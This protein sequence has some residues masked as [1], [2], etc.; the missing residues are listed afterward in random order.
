MKKILYVLLSVIGILGSLLSI[1]QFVASLI[2]MEFGR[3][4]FYFILAALCV[5][6]LFFSV[7]RITKK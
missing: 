7:M 5:E 6:L 1:W 4:L 3:V 2:F